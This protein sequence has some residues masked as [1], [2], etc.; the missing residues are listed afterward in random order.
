MSHSHT[1]AKCIDVTIHMP[2]HLSAPLGLHQ[3]SVSS[4]PL[5]CSRRPP[6]QNTLPPYLEC[7][8]SVAGWSM[9]L[10]DQRP[11][12]RSRYSACFHKSMRIQNHSLDDRCAAIRNME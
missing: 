5:P 6:V 4:E 7:L 10:A 8:T 12:L 2:A 9:R 11:L 3:A 1:A